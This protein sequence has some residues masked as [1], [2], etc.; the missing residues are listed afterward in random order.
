MRV[1]LAIVFCLAVSVTSSGAEQGLP[2]Q[3]TPQL[4]QAKL[5]P[6]GHLVVTYVALKRVEVITYKVGDYWWESEGELGEF[7]IDE[8]ET[9]VEIRG[10]PAQKEAAQKIPVI[11][12]VYKARKHTE[13]LPSGQ[14]W[15]MQDGKLHESRKVREVLGQETRAVVFVR[16][17]NMQERMDPFYAKFLRPEVIV[18]GG[19]IGQPSYHGR[20]TVVPPEKSGK[21]PPVSEQQTDETIGVPLPVPL[22]GDYQPGDY[23]PGDYH[24]LPKVFPSL[25]RPRR[26]Q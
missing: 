26:Q 5:Q 11:S 7:E 19:K 12:L 25:Q 2:A 21:V 8:S 6:D 9:G 23:Q 16:V 17:H 15:V 10:R 4:A 20:A 22:P 3:T 18:V 24:K 13:V 14:F 1:I